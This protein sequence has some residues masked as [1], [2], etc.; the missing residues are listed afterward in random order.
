MRLI[1]GVCSANSIIILNFMAKSALLRAV[2]DIV[3]NLRQMAQDDHL[4]RPYLT[5]YLHHPP[6]TL[7]TF[8]AMLEFLSMNLPY[9]K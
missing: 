3:E 9:T 5:R 6:Q 2:P 4:L 1:K 7:P 8:W